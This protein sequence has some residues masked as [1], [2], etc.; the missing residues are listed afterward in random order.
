MTYSYFNM[1][2]HIS[3]YNLYISSYLVYC[4]VSVRER[5]VCV[6]CYA[7]EITYQY[8]M[9]ELLRYV[10]GLMV[11]SGCRLTVWRRIDVSVPL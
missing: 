1:S 5:D 4:V 8:L 3:R 2:T 9:N 7:C 6:L 10:Q 11:S